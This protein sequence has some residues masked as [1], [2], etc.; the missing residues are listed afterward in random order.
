MWIEVPSAVLY[1]TLGALVVAA[2]WLQTKTHSIH[3]VREGVVVQSW[4]DA[5]NARLVLMISVAFLVITPLWGLVSRPIVTVACLAR[6]ALLAKRVFYG[7]PLGGLD[8]NETRLFIGLPAL[9]VV[10]VLVGVPAPLAKFATLVTIT[11]ALTIVL[12]VEREIDNDKGRGDQADGVLVMIARVCR[13]GLRGVSFV[14]FVTVVQFVMG[15]TYWLGSH[16]WVIV[17]VPSV[18]L[19]VLLVMSFFNVQISIPARL[20]KEE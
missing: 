7:R 1:P 10:D 18:L 16:A 12:L 15:A 9:V 20:R 5:F 19:V 6:L 14:G 8:M 4:L 17:A 11:S 2:L 3:K 13:W